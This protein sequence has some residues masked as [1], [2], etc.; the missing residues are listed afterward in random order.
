REIEALQLAPLHHLA[1]ALGSLGRGGELYHSARVELASNR[2]ENNP[3]DLG[4]RATGR[5]RDGRQRDVILRVRVF[6]DAL[7]ATA[8]GARARQGFD[9]T[10]DGDPRAFVRLDW[11]ARLEARKALR[12]IESLQTDRRR[13]PNRGVAIGQC[14]ADWIGRAIVVGAREVED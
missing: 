11:C 5:V 14:S 10:C 7:V 9:R 4:L 6:L 1:R 2:V 3:L 13:C 8:P 12:A